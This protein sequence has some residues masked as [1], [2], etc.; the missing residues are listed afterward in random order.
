[1]TVSSRFRRLA[2]AFAGFAGGLVGLG[3]AAAAQPQSVTPSEAPVAW[4]RYA[5]SVTQS[6]T[7]WLEEDSQPATAFRAYLHQT[8]PA[9][10]QPT[11]PLVLKVWINP[12]GRVDRI[13]FT[14]FADEPANAD[15][16]AAIVGRD[17][18]AA[19]PRGMLLPLRLA[20]QL[21]ASQPEPAGGTGEEP[22]STVTAEAGMPSS[23]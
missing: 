16:R 8:R 21:E 14:P 22:S 2:G 17:L 12:D 23:G 6:I 9:E 18:S 15:L 11:P 5:E 10:D 4:V 3:G 13:D 7:I 20:I 19:P 1:M